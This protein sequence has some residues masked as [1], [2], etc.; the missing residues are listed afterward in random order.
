MRNVLFSNQNQDLLDEDKLEFDTLVKQTLYCLQPAVRSNL[1]ACN[2]SSDSNL[3]ETIFRSL[4]LCK[5][6]CFFDSVTKDKLL[7]RQTLSKRKQIGRTRLADDDGENI[8]IE[9]QYSIDRKEQNAE[10]FKLLRI[11]MAWN[12]IE[13]AKEWIFRGS[14][15]HI[16]VRFLFEYYLSN[17]CTLLQDK[18]QAFIDA[19]KNKLPSFVDEFLNLGIDPS[20]TFFGQK[21]LLQKYRYKKF[22]LNLY[23]SKEVV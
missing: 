17:N 9:S 1:T 12:C 19:L 15:N 5:L 21:G 14:L 8:E 2:L 13:A 4:C 20:E 23:T 6:R 22:L 18:H 3:S 16:L 10:R 11:A 7:A